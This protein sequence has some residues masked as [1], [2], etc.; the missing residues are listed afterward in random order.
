M[1]GIMLTL[2]LQNVVCSLRS[3]V[4]GLSDDGA[5]PPTVGY[6]KF[7]LGVIYDLTKKM[8]AKLEAAKA[9]YRGLR[10]IGISADTWTSRVG[11]GFIGIEISFVFVDEDGNF[12][13]I[14]M[15]L[16]CKFVSGSHSA[17]LLAEVIREVLWEF[18]LE[19][20][21]IVVFTSD[22]GG[23]I[24]ACAKVLGWARRPCDLHT[25]DTVDGW[26][27]GMKGKGTG[28]HKHGPRASDIKGLF[29]RMNG[30]AKVFKNATQKKEVLSNKMLLPQT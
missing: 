17:E 25:L 27:L 1:Q 28:S 14:R 2:A 12:V 24:P 20:G 5:T 23:G 19:V 26:A 16:A 9:R 30:Q 29:L 6:L 22:S 15:C 3:L 7:I 21:D 11:K 4:A 18:G 13:I 10:F 8:K